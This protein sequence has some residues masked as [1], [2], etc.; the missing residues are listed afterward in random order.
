[1]LAL[2]S[3]I[4]IGCGD[5]GSQSIPAQ[6]DGAAGAEST[7]GVCCANYN[8]GEALA[9][10]WWVEGGPIAPRSLSCELT[11]SGQTINGW[12]TQSDLGA[13]PACL[14]LTS[15]GAFSG[16]MSTRSGYLY[17][18]AGDGAAPLG[19]CGICQPW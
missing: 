7:Q 13:A 9:G 2:A 14:F 6:I 4:T 15:S 5:Q 16:A 10:L 3:V 19:A 11:A 1:M 12:S 18:D 17:L 8:N